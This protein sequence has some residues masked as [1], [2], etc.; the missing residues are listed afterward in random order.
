MA[1]KHRICS[2]LIVFKEIKI[3]VVN[4]LS[5]FN[6]RNLIIKIVFGS[7]LLRGHRISDIPVATSTSNIP[8]C[9]SKHHSPVKRITA[10]WRNG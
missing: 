2:L 6:H 9:L 7:C 3:K 4:S 8:R 10:P 5:F 1:C